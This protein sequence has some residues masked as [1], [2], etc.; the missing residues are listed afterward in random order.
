MGMPC[1]L[2]KIIKIARVN[3]LPVVEDAACAVGSRINIDNSWESIGQPH[4][5]IACFSFH[6]R[7]VMTTGNGGM[8]T[9]RNGEFDRQF[10]LWRQH[11]MSIPDTVR[12]NARRVTNES[13][14]DV[15]YNYRMTDIQAAVGREQL[16]AL[17][18]T[19]KVRRDIARK[20]TDLLGGICGLSLPHEPKWAESNWQSFCVRLPKQC[21]Q[22]RTMQF[23]LDAGIST[24]RGIMCSHRE[25]PYLASHRRHQLIESESAQDNCIILPL[26]VKM[27]NEQMETICRCLAEACSQCMRSR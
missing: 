24:R 17:P 15:G 23:M 3:S 20:Y 27:T 11:G 19:V 4:G 21:D 6:P 26:F 12:H 13:Y 2:A 9:T 25:P 1:D 16:K 22:L 7:K 8:L 5:D 18:E 10:R 14:V